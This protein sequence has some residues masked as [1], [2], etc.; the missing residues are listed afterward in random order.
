MVEMKLV[1]MSLEGGQRGLG[2]D[3]GRHVEEGIVVMMAVLKGVDAFQIEKME[4]TLAG[5][6]STWMLEYC[7]TLQ[8]KYF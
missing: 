5:K 3:E 2:G 4:R 1:E 8:L 7:N 6:L